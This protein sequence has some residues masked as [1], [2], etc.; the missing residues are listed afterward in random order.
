L[1]AYGN[2]RG[3]KESGKI[4]AAPT[5]FFIANM[6]VLLTI[7]GVRLATSS[8]HQRA[9]DAEGMV[10]VGTHHGSGLLMGATVFIVLKAF[11]SGGAA[12]PGGEAFSNGVPAFRAPA[13]KNARSTLVAMG[14]ILGVMFLGLS[15]LAAK[16][17]AMPYEGGTPTVI[18]QVGKSVYG[19]GAAGHLL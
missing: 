2:L 4:F 14:A 16:S 6:A 13:W 15:V 12:S 1:I 8:L 9:T 5:Y 7:G 18:S 3:T 10:P 11:G 17:H 19:G